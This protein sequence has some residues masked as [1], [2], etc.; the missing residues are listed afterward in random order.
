[1]AEHS[2]ADTAT[3]DFTTEAAARSTR[4]SARAQ[5]N[6]T[7]WED[8]VIP[9]PQRVHVD[10]LSDR[11][12]GLTAK[13]DILERGV[14]NLH[15][16]RDVVQKTP[17]ASAPFG[18]ASASF[19]DRVST[20]LR[21]RRRSRQRRDSSSGNDDDNNQ[22]RPAAA[23]TGTGFQ[24]AS[25][26]FGRYPDSNTSGVP[27]QPLRNSAKRGAGQLAGHDRSN[28][29]DLTAALRSGLEDLKSDGKLKPR[30]VHELKTLFTILD[31]D[32]LTEVHKLIN[33]RLSELYIAGARGWTEVKN[34]QRRE[35]DS[36]LGL[37]PA[38]QSTTVRFAQ[39]R[40]TNYK[41]KTSNSNPKK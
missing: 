28:C 41:K 17:S 27:E 3:G 26:G 34:Y 2:D 13:F 29:N 35:V 12:S 10:D 21:P 18:G 23:S 40:K 38:Q 16:E 37:Q 32:S 9:S 15:L 31:T 24:P 14:A 36:L 22:Q 20:E 6:A 33:N 11:I 1:M 25:S 30:D 5:Q 8:P 39:P 19:F 4:Q 7:G